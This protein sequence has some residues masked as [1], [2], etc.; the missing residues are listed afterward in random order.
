[1]VGIGSL[2]E[3]SFDKGIQRFKQVLLVTDV[4][5][6]GGER[7]HTRVSRRKQSRRRRWISRR[8]EGEGGTKRRRDEEKE[9]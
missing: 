9:G 8:K 2:Q 4:H 5:I 6:Q 1:M 3:V 7:L